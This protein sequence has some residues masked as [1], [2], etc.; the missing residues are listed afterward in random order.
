MVLDV[1]GAPAAGVPLSRGT[2]VP[3]SVRHAAGGVGRNIAECITALTRDT[4]SPAPLLI[5]TV[6]DDPA[7]Q[8][9]TNH[10]RFVNLPF[11][12][13]TTLSGL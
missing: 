1:Q 7:G 12:P 5:S 8:F 4:P 2:T 10:L 9:L 11:L 13:A 6:G 3:G